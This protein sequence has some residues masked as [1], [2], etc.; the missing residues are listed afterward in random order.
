MAA[1]FGG[2][3]HV[4]ISVLIGG[5]GAPSATLRALAEQLE[6]THP[7]HHVQVVDLDPPRPGGQQLDLAAAMIQELDPGLIGAACSPENV[8]Q[9]LDLC[10][11]IHRADP[12]RA[13][14]LMGPEAAARREELLALEA[15]DHVLD[16]GLPA[17]LEQLG[18]LIRPEGPT[19]GRASASA[20][21]GTSPYGTR[22][23]TLVRSSR[24]LT[25]AVEVA[26]LV[27]E[28]FTDEEALNLLRPLLR[29]GL[30]VR[31]RDAR[32]C[33]DRA[34]LETLLEQL[35]G[36]NARLE[37]TVPAQLLD[38]ALVDRLAAGGLRRLEVDLTRWTP[39][40]QHLAALLEP[41]EEGRI[42]L[43][44]ALT[45]GRPDQAPLCELVDHGLA[46]GLEDLDLDR[47]TVPP[48]SSLRGAEAAHEL[49]YATTPP[50]GVISHREAS[51]EAILGQVRF[52]AAYA[53]LRTPLAGT[54]ILRTLTGNLGSA[55]EVIEGFAE[56]LTSQGH[57]PL[58]G[59]P[60]EPIERLFTKHLREFHGIDLALDRSN[61]KLRRAPSISLR[62]LEG[63][64]RVVTDDATGRVAHLGGW[65]L[66]LIDRFDRPR[67]A[68]EACEQI[69]EEAPADRRSK[70]RADLRLTVQ[71]LA[72]LGFLI[73]TPAEG[74]VATTTGEA[75]F[76]GLEEFDY[77]YRMLGDTIR[78]D[79][80][81]RAIEQVVE[82][83]THV[84]EIGTGTGVLAVLAARAGAR[85]T[86]LEQYALVQLAREVVQASGVKEQ[87]KLVRG[88]SDQVK[89][90]ERGDL[91]ISEL[92][93]NRILNEGL[94]EVTI[95]ARERLL[96][97]GAE[98]IPRRIEILAELGRT[99]RFAHLQ[100]EFEQLGQRYDVDLSPLLGWF[101]GRLEAGRM[102]W[103]LN[104]EED[105]FEP[106][107]AAQRVIDLDLRQITSPGFSR[108]IHLHPTSAGAANAV[109]LSFRLELQPGIEISTLGRDHG[110]HWGKPVFML[111]EPVELRPGQAHSVNVSYEPHGELCVEIAD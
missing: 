4:A 63:G 60:P 76:T 6:R 14:A 109:V 29:V 30:A 39:D 101:D 5:G 59:P 26:P 22:V 28:G 32:L 18:L 92:V 106:L 3:E 81:R 43:G 99:R 11:R 23:E 88:R 108:Q 51:A 34:R 58:A 111:R 25:T 82:P 57:D 66:D 13:V 79:A 1:L 55:F 93:G 61:L 46:A 107:T 10:D 104:Q 19:D 68:F 24:R 20:R 72:A 36:S 70:L 103:E 96:R 42:S 47:L 16:G 78:V 102:L 69:V 41:L 98:L 27:G 83:G 80:Y 89:L 86:A 35:S 49:R 95:D 53:L 90:D 71:K 94:L 52:A 48:F 9:I 87:V 8:V 67:T 74:A 50:Y 91:L 100:R 56:Q 64:R 73:T 7:G 65:A 45:Y 37:L 62:W 105:D 31:L 33:G 85:V 38:R 75:P 97:P 84:V 77:H 15:V 110:L 2:G 44:G 17:V 54:G 12:R 21:A 40:G